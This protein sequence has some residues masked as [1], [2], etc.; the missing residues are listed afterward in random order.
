MPLKQVSQLVSPEGKAAATA[1]SAHGWFIHNGTG[2]QD[3][4]SRQWGDTFAPPRFGN[5]VEFY[6]TGEEYYN[7]LASVFATAKDSIYITGWQVNFDVE[8]AGGKTLFEHLELAMSVNKHL[9]VY[10]MP[11]LSPK[12]GVNTGDFETMLAIFQLNAGVG[13][14]P[15]AFA[16]PAVGQSDMKDGL[17]IGFSHHQKLVVIDSKLA[18]V[19]GIDL[20]YG[21]RD[22]GKF[23]LRHDGRTGS[24]LYNPCIPPMHKIDHVER[25]NYLTRWEL[26]AAC[27]DGMLGGIGVFFTAASWKPIAIGLDTAATGAEVIGEARKKASEWWNSSSILPA[28]L[29]EW[30]KLAVDKAHEG[31]RKGFHDLDRKLGGKLEFLHNTASASA[32]DAAANLLSWLN[33]GNMDALPAEKQGE[34]AKV[35]ELFVLATMNLL[36]SAAD[37]R[38]T[39]YANLR[40]LRKMLPTGAAMISSSQPRMPWHDVHSSIEGP[41][42]SDLCHNFERRWNGVAQRYEASFR[43]LNSD[44][45]LRMIFSALHVAPIGSVTLP[46]IALS[47][48]AETQPKIASCWVQTL[49]SAPLLLQHNEIVAIAGAMKGV[50]PSL[51]QDNCLKATINAIMG[52]QHFIYIEGQFFQTAYGSENPIKTARISG[53]MAALI[54]ITVRPEYHKYMKILGIENAA[55]HDIVRKMNWMKFGE[56]TNDEKYKSFKLDLILVLKNL[57]SIKASLAMG[58]EQAGMLNPVGEALERSVESAIRD[59]RNFHVYIVLPVHPEGTLATLNILTQIHLTMQS[60]IFG[61]QSLVNRIRRAILAGGLARKMK[62]NFDEAKKIVASYSIERLVD[63]AGGRWSNYLT[64]LNLRNWESLENRVVTEQIYVHS[65]L[66]VADDRVAIIGSANLNDRSLLGNRD[67]ELAIMVRD[68]SQV[69]V[70]LDGV[71]TQPVSA[72]VHGLRVRLWRKLFGLMGGANPATN[73]EG[74]IAHPAAP[75]TWNAIQL[76]AKQN[77]SAYEN[78][79][80][81]LPK[82]SGNESSIWPTW[83]SET[84]ALKSHMPFSEK[85][86]LSEVQRE[87]SFTW[88][89]KSHI[90]EVAPIGVRGFIVALPTAWTLNENN[91]SGMNLS[92]LSDAVKTLNSDIG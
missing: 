14:P 85:F 66:L 91:F 3:F 35:M 70:K 74:V 21:R 68:D 20:A 48:G 62:I 31:A 15:R 47:P 38:L 83:D 49:R 56:V 4:E 75:A 8:L 65:K 58:S 29:A 77:A 44:P 76:V 51:A 71:H 39:R 45:A 50:I 79:F 32:A 60:L 10:V 90:P 22:N 55:P 17:A 53:P 63:E 57:A 34:A 9:R 2:V 54:D 46:R 69:P 36:H 7:K 52:A 41:S 88:D 23:L 24:E 78:G 40:T 42:V 86:W 28:F 72:S 26:F 25:C 43:S 81:F 80:A 18:F 59:N 5:K 73:L 19:G 12:V 89:A 61:T 30:Q 33:N 84:H 82:P 11:W 37:K 87:A 6:V 16:L 64:L 67:S 92:L 27:F 13:G 1:T